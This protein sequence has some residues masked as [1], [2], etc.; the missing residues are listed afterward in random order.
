MKFIVIQSFTQKIEIAILFGA[1]VNATG[2]K[3]NVVNVANK[4]NNAWKFKSHD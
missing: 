3:W 1:Q 2:V 4:K